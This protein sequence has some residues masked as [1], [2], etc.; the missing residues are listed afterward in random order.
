MRIPPNTGSTPPSPPSQP[1]KP[2]FDEAKSFMD[3]GAMLHNQATKTI[4]NHGQTPKAKALDEEALENFK[5]AKKCLEKA[6][7][8]DPSN[9]TYQSVL[10]GLN[11]EI[12]TLNTTLINWPN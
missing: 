11:T 10:D 1:G 3:K 7:I 8:E 9:K 12:S 5:W 6:L 2:Y 4:D